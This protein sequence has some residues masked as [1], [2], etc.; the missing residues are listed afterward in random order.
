MMGDSLSICNVNIDARQHILFV[1]P[2]VATRIGY[3][4]RQQVAGHFPQKSH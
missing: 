4:L 1:L 2:T 3:S